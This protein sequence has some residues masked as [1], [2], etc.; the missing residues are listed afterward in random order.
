MVIKYNPD[1]DSYEDVQTVT[2]SEKQIQAEITAAQGRIDILTA[3][4]AEQQAIIDSLSVQVEARTTAVAAKAQ[5][6][7]GADQIA[8][9]P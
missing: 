9:Q 7:V 5:L 4:I 8:P 6:K 1:T 3:Q 2:M